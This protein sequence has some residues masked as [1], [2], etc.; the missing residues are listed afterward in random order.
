MI[1]LEYI[2]GMCKKISHLHLCIDINNAYSQVRL[3][4]ILNSTNLMKVSW[5]VL[6]PRSGSVAACEINALL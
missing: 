3:M 5:I 2:L 1:K 4:S 6:S